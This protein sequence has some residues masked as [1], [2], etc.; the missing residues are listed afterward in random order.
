MELVKNTKYKVDNLRYN[1]GSYQIPEDCKN[2]IAIDIGCNNGCFL[3]QN[4]DF[5]SKIYAYEA[6]YFLVEKLK[7]KFNKDSNIEIN[8]AAVSNESK[9]ILKLIKYKYN[10][11]NGSFAILKNNTIEQW[12]ISELICE[13]ESIN[14]ESILQKCDYK[15]DFLKI[16]CETSEYEF[17]LNKDLKNIKYIAIELHNQL[18]KERYEELYN[19]I[20]K[21]HNCNQMCNFIEN[22]NQ[23]VLFFNKII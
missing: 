18:G 2:G 19:F 17:L 9:N 20:L 23:E 3:D 16:D 6:N 14:I 1:Y 4:K 10:D 5:F 7:E 13:V 8:H 22:S 12:D 15:I 21:S 11:E